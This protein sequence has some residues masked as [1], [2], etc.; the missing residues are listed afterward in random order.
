MRSQRKKPPRS[1]SG[2]AVLEYVLTIAIVVAFVSAIAG[3]FRASVIRLW[4]VMTQEVSAPCIG[5]PP[6]DQIRL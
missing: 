5:C 3:I 1:K 2:Q 6:D 4:E